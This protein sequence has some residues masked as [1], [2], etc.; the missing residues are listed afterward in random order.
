MRTLNRSLLVLATLAALIGLLAVGPAVAAETT[1]TAALVGGSAEVP[2]AGD[3]DGTGSATITIDPATNEVCWDLTTTN[4]ADVVVSHIHVG[5]AGAAGPVVV[6]LDVDGFS[7]TST[8]CVTDAVADLEAILTTPAGFYVNVHT[9][10]FPAG[11]IRGQLVA[12]APPPDT[13]MA[14]SAATPLV[15][16]GALVLLLGL[17]AGLRIVRARA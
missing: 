1:L 2:D 17:A 13:A 11:A 8:G 10:D 6:N 15:V 14:P 5:A 3:P 16:I 7:G 12:A 4:I 9:G